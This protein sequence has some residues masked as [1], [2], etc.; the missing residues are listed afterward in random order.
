M[1]HISLKIK[2]NEGQDVLLGFTAD[3]IV[4]N[5]STTIGGT[6]T[7][8]DG[9]NGISLAKKISLA[10]GFLGGRNAVLQSEQQKYNGFMFGATDG[11]GNYS[12]TLIISGENLDAITIVGDRTAN[13]F[14]TVA[15]IDGSKTIYSDDLVWAIR[16]D[17]VA[18]LHTVEF[19]KWNRAN[20]NACFTTLSVLL[21]YLE[22][23]R[24][25]IDSVESLGQSTSNNTS[26]Q[27]GFL[28]NSGTVKVR[29]L[30]GE[31][32]DYV[33][34]GVISEANIPVQVLLNGEVVRSHITTD[35]D[36]DMGN[37][38]L[39]FS[40][41]NTTGLLERDFGGL[42][43]S[44]RKTAYE[45]LCYVLDEMGY[46]TTQISK[47]LSDKI[48]VYIGEGYDNGTISGDS[49][50]TNDVLTIEE[51]LKKITIPYAYL[52]SSTFNDALN[53]ICELAQLRFYL[54]N[55]RL[56]KFE[57][58]RPVADISNLSKIVMIHRHDIIGSDLKT[59]LFKK[60]KIKTVGYVDKHEVCEYKIIDTLTVAIHSSVQHS[61]DNP[62]E[63]EPFLWDSLDNANENNGNF[64]VLNFTKSEIKDDLGSN[65]Q[66]IITQLEGDIRYTPKEPAFNIKN[67]KL[68]DRYTSDSKY[69]V[70]LY[71]ADSGTF[72]QNIELGWAGEFFTLILLG[73]IITDD[74][75]RFENGSYIFP[76][77]FRVSTDRQHITT[78]GAVDNRWAINR[79][80]Y[81]QQALWGDTI[82]FN[83]ET[84]RK[85]A[86][87]VLPTNELMHGLVKYGETHNMI[88]DCIFPQILED[89]KNGVD[90]ATLTVF[91]KNYKS[92]NGDI[93][94]GEGQIIE[95]GQIVAVDGDLYPNGNQRY[96]KVTGSNIVYNG[97]GTQSLELQEIVHTIGRISLD[98]V[99]P[100]GDY[101]DI[102][103]CVDFKVNGETTDLNTCFTDTDEIYIRF[104]RVSGLLA[105][106]LKINGR[107][108][109]YS[110]AQ[111]LAGDGLTLKNCTNLR[112]EGVAYIM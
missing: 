80:L 104:K 95:V 6:T 17:D 63:T 82:S 59:S 54:D 108:L 15:I 96:W 90:T 62:K 32:L 21:E 16:F 89:Y 58:I 109:T 13:Q 4:N 81:I 92:P 50:I 20:Y 24:S 43:A 31:F 9:T 64:T 37:R 26:I 42:Y 38:I 2:V 35:S 75:Q 91:M 29:D 49:S 106:P 12:L 86:D 8:S 73:H 69:S 30:D 65:V 1:A 11:D 112:I 111:M 5:V 55:D 99:Y 72:T 7:K 74:S 103:R 87:F 98:F 51:Y 45:V 66:Q 23:N 77:E 19:T 70:S 56:P 85:N 79:L 36:Y 78:T 18:P 22:L 84:I 3:K 105:V 52:E 53:K 94:V 110:E 47:M 102:T 93:V 67:N 25:W 27:Y 100:T 97:S 101:A 57:S 44:E 107:D 76:F 40:L 46:N 61:S 33:N 48:W 71:S 28:A 39:S 34:D 60:N 10:D 88:K 68:V 41:S 14:P 83:D